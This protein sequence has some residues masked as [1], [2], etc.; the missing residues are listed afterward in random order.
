MSDSVEKYFDLVD[1][2]A[3]DL[4]VN[5]SDT[6]DNKIFYLLAAAAKANK[7]AEVEE[8]V[9]EVKKEYNSSSLLLALEIACQGIL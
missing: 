1:E 5:A 7:L 2:G 4:D 8:R 3:I 9:E 6:R